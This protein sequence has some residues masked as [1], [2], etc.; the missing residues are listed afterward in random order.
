MNSSATERLL[1]GIGEIEDGFIVEAQTAEVDGAK[2][3]KR[4]RMAYGAAGIVVTIGIAVAYWKLRP[5]R[6]A[7][8]A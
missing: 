5:N 6:L 1:D 7:T 2:M 3:V 4:K 8:S